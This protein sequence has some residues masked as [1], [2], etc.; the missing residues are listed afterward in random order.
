MRIPIDHY[1]SGEHLYNMMVAPVC[2]KYGLT[3]MEFTVAMFLAN[4]TQYDTA[5]QIVKLRRLTKSHVSVSVRSLLQK[6]LLTG[7]YRED[8]HRTVHLSLTE[9]TLPI[10]EE[11]RLVQEQFFNAIFSGFTEG[12]K[13]Q[14]MEFMSRIDENIKSGIREEETK[15]GKE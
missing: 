2:E 1:A 10:V 7:E 14:M 3:H 12:E 6:G 15:N 9:D 5:A 13:Q 11:G 4:N 8:N